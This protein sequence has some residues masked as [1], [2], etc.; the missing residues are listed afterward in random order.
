MKSGFDGVPA[1]RRAEAYRIHVEGW[2][3]QMKAIEQY[4][5]KAA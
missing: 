3:G 1:A 4:L 5:A 2:A